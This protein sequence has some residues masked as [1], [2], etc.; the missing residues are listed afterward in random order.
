M[1]WIV[2]GIKLKIEGEFLLLSN[3][4]EAGISLEL[5]RRVR[6]KAQRG[7]LTPAVKMVKF[8]WKSGHEHFCHWRHILIIFKINVCTLFQS[9]FQRRKIPE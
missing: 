8:L 7:Q 1:I 3:S 9:S 6:L 5:W 4:G 2:Q